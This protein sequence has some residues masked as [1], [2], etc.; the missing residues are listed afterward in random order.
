MDKVLGGLNAVPGV[1]G[2]MLCDSHGRVLAHEFV[3]RIGGTVL[4]EAAA[5]LADGAVA[6]ETVTGPLGLVDFRYENA[7]VVARSVPGALL[8][9]LCTK[10]VNL[11]LAWMAM[12]V[13]SRRFEELAASP[14][15]L[16]RPVLPPEPEDAGGARSR[17]GVEDAAPRAADAPAA[18]T[19][20][21]SAWWPSV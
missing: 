4:Q 18:A 16:E 11:P 13:V 19:E 15:G 5:V 21:G 2:S 12:S 1:M 6:L 17:Q 20:K 9:A 7:R 3:E 8:L 10:A 14:D